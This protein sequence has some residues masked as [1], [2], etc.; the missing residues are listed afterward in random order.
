M[1]ELLEKRQFLNGKMYAD[2]LLLA[3]AR[4]CITQIICYYR[5]LNSKA[6]A[7]VRD[8]CNHEVLRTVVKAYPVCKLPIKQRMFVCAMQYKM[9]GMLWCL[10]KLNLLM[11]KHGR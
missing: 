5:C 3:R 9:I 10:V 6:R 4:V 11:K 2:R 1:L 7:E 8:I